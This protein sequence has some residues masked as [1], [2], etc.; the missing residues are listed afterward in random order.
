MI[1]EKIQLNFNGKDIPLPSKSQYIKKLILQ[2]EKFLKNIRWKVFWF[3]RKEDQ[4]ELDDEED[5]NPQLKILR[6]DFKS[7]KTP[8][9]HELLKPFERDIYHLIGNVE[10]RK[11]QDPRLLEMGKEAKRIRER[12]DIIINADK[13]NN[14]YGV[15]LTDYKQSLL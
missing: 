8:P 14:R 15:S 4:Q 1:L 9:T 13:T 2:T 10:F 5:D 7:T 3:E 11:I 6:S 12:K